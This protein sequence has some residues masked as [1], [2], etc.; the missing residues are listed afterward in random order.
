MHPFKFASMLSRIMYK[1]R[2]D[3]KFILNFVSIYAVD[4]NLYA[5]EKHNVN[6]NN[7]YAKMKAMEKF[8]RTAQVR[9][10]LQSN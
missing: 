10:E 4:H 6:I 2:Y 5:K 1:A 3:S 7:T 8:S 9:E